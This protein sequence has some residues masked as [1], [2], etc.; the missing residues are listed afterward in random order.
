MDVRR[1]I[2]EVDDPLALQWLLEHDEFDVALNEAHLETGLAQ[3]LIVGGALSDSRLRMK[4]FHTQDYV[5]GVVRILKA[6]HAFHLY[7]VSHFL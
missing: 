2:D 6:R 7:F 1:A 4:L 3:F 5:L